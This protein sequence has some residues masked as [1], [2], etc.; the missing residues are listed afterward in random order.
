MKRNQQSF[1][2]AIKYRFLIGILL[3]LILWQAL[4]FFVD[5]RLIPSPADTIKMFVTLMV[6]G[7]LVQHTGYSLFRL[8]CAVLLALVSGVISGLAIG[9]I[10][11]LDDIFSPVIYILFPVPKAALLPIIF[12]LFGLGDGSKIILIW[13]I[14]YFQIVLAVYDAAKNIG[15]DI[16]LSA[17]T[18]RLTRG[19]LYHHII[20]PAIL[21]NVLTA[22]RTSVGIG[23]AV[24]FF[25]ETYATKYGLGY[26][27]MNNWALLNFTQ[28]YAGII[29]L[30]GMGFAIFSV[31]DLIKIKVIKW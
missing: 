22:L 6:S 17:R 11:I 15:Q 9:M 29:T 12:V 4:H 18:L 13:L 28:M 23:I 31:I 21:P 3:I 25:A 14:L 26:F 16:L 8:G 5:S 1:R 19:Q 7:E 27:I 24:L 10:R 30:G 2:A 20:L